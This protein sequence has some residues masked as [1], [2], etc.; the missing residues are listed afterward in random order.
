[1]LIK[2]KGIIHFEP[3]DKT[4]KH[5]SQSSCKRVAMILT[6][7]D[8]CEYYAWFIKKR[9]NLELNKPLRGSHITIINDKDKEVPLFN[10]AK[11]IFD[12]KE[13]TFYIDPEPRTNGEHWWLRVYCADAEALRVACGGKK[14]PYYAFHLTIGYAAHLRLEHSNYVLDLCKAY[15]IISSDPRKPFDEHDIIEF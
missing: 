1:M 5:I 7:D 3:K 8:L 6:N 15:Q 12:K 4:K 9:F 13:I 2:A 11:G 10:Q 14:D